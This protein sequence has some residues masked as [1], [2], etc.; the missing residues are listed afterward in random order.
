MVVGVEVAAV[1]PLWVEVSAKEMA[2]AEEAA[3]KVVEAMEVA[4]VEASEMAALAA[5]DSA[6]HQCIEL[7]HPFLCVQG[8]MSVSRRRGRSQR[9][10]LLSDEPAHDGHRPS[11]LPATAALEVLAPRRGGAKPPRKIVT[12]QHPHQQARRQED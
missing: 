4:M 3:V 5:K 10:R 6:G 1:A 8:P 7:S 11:S 2:K 9:Q 12:G